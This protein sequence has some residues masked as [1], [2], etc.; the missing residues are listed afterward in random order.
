M[1]NKKYNADLS[2]PDLS[3]LDIYCK[4]NG[5][6]QMVKEKLTLILSRIWNGSNEIYMSPFSKAKSDSQLLDDLYKQVIIPNSAK[7]N[8]KLMSMENEQREKF[9]PRS[10]AVPWLKWR[11][12]FIS[13]FE[14]NLKDVKISIKIPDY[15]RR[16]RP[17]S[18]SASSK[19]LKTATSSSLPYMMRKS[20]VLER[21]L[22]N[23]SS[24]LV[25]KFP[26]VLYSR[27]QENMKI[28][29]VWGY[30]IAATLLEAS[31]FYPLLNVRR[32]LR[33]RSSLI[34]PD[35]TSKRI[36]YLLDKASKEGKICLSIDIE[37]FDA[38]TPSVISELAFS[39]LA[40]YFQ[41]MYEEGFSA[42]SGMFSNIG[43]I[44]PD[45]I[46]YGE[47]GVPSG[48]N[49]TNEIDS[50]IQMLISTDSNTVDVDSFDIQGDDGAYVID[51]VKVASLKKAFEKYGYKVSESKSYISPDFFVYLQK[52]Y[53][54]DYRDEKDLVNGIYPIVRALNR[55]RYQERWSQFEEYNMTG[56]DYYSL[57]TITILENCRFH[58]LFEEFVKF[59]LDNDK[60]SLAFSRK[61]LKQYVNML[62]ETEGNRGN[63]SNQY[64]DDISGLMSFE[65]VKLIR[66][67]GS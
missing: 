2:T 62:F 20:L 42:V 3:F 19:K 32:T 41:S 58:P 7:L 17:L 18:I 66:K 13:T 26:C 12:Q 64:G 56:Q 24:D 37:T 8:E 59:V 53:H 23:Y 15:G 38:S 50:E 60:Y 16:L 31:F 52:L 47:H 22:K 44:T 11:S 25:T 29:G 61:G 51:E 21:T 65:S 57:R 67:L 6:D 28:R 34:G 48:S 10:I 55:I 45:G 40:T 49:F 46:L 63:F 30:P 4:E 35:A 33:W 5:L 1:L 9:S 43:I 14:N 39:S 36:T 27:T 54:R